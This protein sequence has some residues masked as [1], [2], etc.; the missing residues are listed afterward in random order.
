MRSTYSAAAVLVSAL[1]LVSAQTF[2][3]C[4][5]TAKTCPADP[6]LG[7][8]LTT[9]FTQGK[10]SDWTLAD[11]TT[12]SY[13]GSKGAVFSIAVGT[14][15]PTISS[16]K[17]IM[18]GKVSVTMEAAPGVGIVSSFIL[19]SDDL[20]EIDWE[21]L[22]GTDTSVESNFFG[23][24]NTTTYNRAVYHPVAQAISAVHTYTID[25][26]AQSIIWSIDGNT[27]RTLAYADPL[28]LG[29]AN[30]PQT[31]MKIKMGNWI[32]CLDAA[33]ASN[34]ATAGTC[35][36]AGGPIDLTKG[37][38]DMYV[39]S[40]TIQDY[41][42]G[43]DYTYSDTS[44]SYQ[45][46][47]SSGTCGSNNNS[48]SSS[49]ASAASSVSSSAT[50]SSSAGSSSATTSASKSASTSS[51]AVLVQTSASNATTTGSSSGGNGT[52]LA[53]TP[54][55]TGTGSAS[56][57]ASGAAAKSTAGS[58]A[59]TGLKPKHSYGVLD[60]AVIALGLGLGYLVM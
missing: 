6:G 10:S 22:G 53:T 30:Y 20:D 12:M 2:T 13:D 16:A 45:S 17:Y 33:A 8:T 35:S 29:G 43:G 55:P 57:T 49:S 52:T 41:G 40:V 18:F 5:P 26:T 4:N 38:F 31:P 21:W 15:A 60:F 14:D 27:V 59:A 25:W 39:K 48:G 42:C 56:G 28:A 23:K 50:A 24:G 58:S 19:E 32:G 9:D 46:I 7:T 3:D 47:K 44:G 1:Q 11:G 37:P 34:P 54:T 51:G 36:W